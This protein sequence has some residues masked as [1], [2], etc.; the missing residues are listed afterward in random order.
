MT[1]SWTRRVNPSFGCSTL[2]PVSWA[3]QLARMFQIRKKSKL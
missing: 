2:I 3:W 1:L